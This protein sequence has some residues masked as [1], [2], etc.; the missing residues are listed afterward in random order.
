MADTQTTQSDDPALEKL[1]AISPVDTLLKSSPTP[2]WKAL[3]Q[4]KSAAAEAAAKVKILERQQELSGIQEQKK[5]IGQ[6]E[7]RRQK[8]IQDTEKEIGEEPYP[9]PTKENFKEF[10]TM[11]SVLSALSFATG[12]SGR[13]AGMAGL[14]ALN[15][16]V[17]GWNKGRKDLFDRNMK[18]FEKQLASYKSKADRKMTLLRASID[19]GGLATEKGKIAAKEAALEDGGYGAALIEQ[20]KLKEAAETF[21]LQTKEAAKV[22]TSLRNAIARQIGKTGGVSGAGGAVQFRYNAAMTNAGNIL[23]TE[24]SNAA[25]LPLS[26]APPAAAE[27]LTNPSA[28]LTDA[29]KSFFAQKSTAA[30]NRAMQQVL[31]GMARAITTIEASGRPS[32]ATEAAIKEF[33]KM[34]PR[35]GDNRINI[36]LSLAQSKQI[37]NILVKDLMANGGTPEQIALAKEAKAQVDSDIPFSVK[38]INRILTGG[39]RTLIDDRVKEALSVSNNLNEFEKQIRPGAPQPATTPGKKVKRTGTITEGVNAGKKIIEYEDGTREI[40]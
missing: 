22:Q 11:F 39:R 1:V 30:E 40:R 8:L 37:M 31:S 16:A 28:S 13:G 24:I 20:G 10:A 4:K 3:E 21:E 2:N 27:V 12:G 36:Y 15:G 19:A 9:T 23:A 34:Q 14:A 25:N 18:E 29:A 35:A 26:A 33:N 32:G 17:E 5:I 6:E 7:E 38:D